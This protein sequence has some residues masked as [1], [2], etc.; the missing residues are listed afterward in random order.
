MIVIDDIDRILALLSVD[1]DA[2]NKMEQIVQ[3]GRNKGIH[4]ITAATT[5]SVNSYS[6]E[7]WF[8]EIRKRSFSYL[9]GTTQNNDLY[10]FN[11]KLPHVEMDREL[12]SG[13]G[14]FVRRKQIKIKCA[15]TPLHLLQDLKQKIARKWIESTRR[16]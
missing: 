1:F 6:H 8:A 12:S 10:F 13:E 14:Y 3:N 16:V 7:K 15:F 9:L 5:S 4:F 11:I 2:K